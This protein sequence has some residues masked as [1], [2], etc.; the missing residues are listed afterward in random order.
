MQLKKVKKEYDGIIFNEYNKS[1]LIIFLKYK[2]LNLE[3]CLLKR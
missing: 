2:G 3:D 1:S